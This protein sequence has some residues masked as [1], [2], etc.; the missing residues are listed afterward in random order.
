MKCLS[1]ALIVPIRRPISTTLSIERPKTAI[2]RPEAMEA[3]II[4]ATLY[5]LEAKVAMMIL[6]W[7]LLKI[8]IIDFA[9]SFSDIE[10]ELT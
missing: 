9:T 10:N 4:W 3:S 5:T 2:F 1:E 7:V 8:S 6:D